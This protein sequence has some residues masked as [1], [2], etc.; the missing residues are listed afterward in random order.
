M[1]FPI[2]FSVIVVFAIIL[3]VTMKKQKKNEPTSTHVEE[4]IVP[5]IHEEIAKTVEEAK[6]L[7]PVEKA[8][9]MKAEPKTVSVKPA[10][11]KAKNDSNP[12]KP[13][14]KKSPKKKVDVQIG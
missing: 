2:I 1:L 8:P 13:Q 14:V 10:A 11:P 6:S 5:S 4:S 7:A 12:T 3:L 9:K